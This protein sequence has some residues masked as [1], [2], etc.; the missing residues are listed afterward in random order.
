M[1]EVIR[2]KKMR[3]FPLKLPSVP[4][5]PMVGKLRMLI[6][7]EISSK[8]PQLRGQVLDEKICGIAGDA[9]K[10]TCAPGGGA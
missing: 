9:L 4:M 8:Y 2:M 3:V 7:G 5:G 6:Q 1:P 10:Y